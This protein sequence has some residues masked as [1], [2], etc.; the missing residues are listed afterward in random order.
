MKIEIKKLSFWYPNRLIFKDADL[1]IENEVVALMGKSGS[2]KSTLIKLISDFYKPTTGEITSDY[3]NLAYVSQSSD[4]TMF[5]WL[6]VEDNIFYPNKLRNTLNDQSKKHCDELLKKFK[7][8]H[9][10]KSFPMNLSEGERKR[11]SLAIALS[12][13]ADCILLDEPFSGIDFKLSN[14]LCQLL[15]EEIK[16]RKISALFITHNIH[17][18]ALLADRI[19]FLNDEKTLHVV[20][21][22]EQTLIALKI[23]RII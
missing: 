18:A 17:E 7:I 15:N 13:N 23:L 6:S 20:E 11:L 21:K 9:L 8:D 22:I 1:T 2:G 10:R 4:K 19:V 5:P 16:L 12:Y 14:E 3:S